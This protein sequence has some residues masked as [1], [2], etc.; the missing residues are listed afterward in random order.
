MSKANEDESSGKIGSKKQDSECWQ[1][2]GI[3]VTLYAKVATLLSFMKDQGAEI[4][5]TVTDIKGA[6]R[7][8]AS[9][10]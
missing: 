6:Y 9:E 3:M 7:S 10:K 2:C 4:V 5:G 1:S 8:I